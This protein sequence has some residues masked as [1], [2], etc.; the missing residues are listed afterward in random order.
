VALLHAAIRT[1]H[2]VAE[3]PGITECL[4]LLA[5]VAVRQGDPVTGAQLIGAAG[6]M[7]AAAGAIRQPDED[8]WAL[9]AIERL[10]TALGEE[11]YAGAVAEGGELAV[12]EAVERA[13]SVG[14]TSR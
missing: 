2:E 13:L 10:R 5:G 7:R 11:A 8:A 12:A 14:L 4:E 1:P 9:D 6:A 3:R